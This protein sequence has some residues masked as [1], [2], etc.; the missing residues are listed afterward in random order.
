MLITKGSDITYLEDYRNG[1][2]KLGLDTGTALD[3]YLRFKRKQIVIILGHDNVGKTYFFE[4][5]ML[6]LA[7]RHGVKFCLWS[8]ENAS[9]QIMRDLIQM[10]HGVPF[11]TIPVGK[12]RSSLGYLEQFFTFIDNKK[13][14]KPKELIQIFNDVE[15]DACLI[16]PYTGLD[17]EM[18]F[19]GNYR[20]LNEVRQ[21]ANTSGKTVYI[22][23]H[24]NTERGRTGHLYPDNHEWGGHLKPPLKSHIE[25][26]KAWLNRSDDVFVV[27]RLCS[28]PT[29]KYETMVSTEKIKDNET[30][31]SL[32]E[33]NQ[34]LLFSFNSGNGFMIQGVDALQNYRATKEMKLKI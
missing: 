2:I 33:L 13:L 9:G 17:R 24:P 15:C 10:Y 25:G 18:T 22:S 30:G 19:E 21:F 12:I 29:M 20:F 16:D 7:L 23:S 5:Y 27:H 31:G 14:Y 3:D 34:P 28:H 26:G 32:T 6:V 8:G 1:K 4:W 11:K